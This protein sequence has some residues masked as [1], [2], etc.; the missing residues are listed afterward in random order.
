[1][2]AVDR[3]IA[4]VDAAPAEQ[5]TTRELRTRLELL[6]AE[7]EQLSHDREHVETETYGEDKFFHRRAIERERSAALLKKTRLLEILGARA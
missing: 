4:R 5:M 3:F 2:R 6:E 1:M 7:L